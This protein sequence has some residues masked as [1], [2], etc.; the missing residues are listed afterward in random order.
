M[1]LT[2][3]YAQNTGL[4]KHSFTSRV[5]ETVNADE[6]SAQGEPDLEKFVKDISMTV[7]MGTSICFQYPS[8]QLTIISLC[9]YV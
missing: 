4:G 7:Y 8:P 1:L 2:W 9:T 5:L 6:L 3:T